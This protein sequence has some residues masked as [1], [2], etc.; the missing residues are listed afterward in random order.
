M[1]GIPFSIYNAIFPTGGI[2]VKDMAGTIYGNIGTT[3]DY[4]TIRAYGTVGLSHT[5]KVVDGATAIANK[6][7]N[8]NALSTTGAKI[9]S[10]YSDNGITEKAYVDKNGKVGV[11]GGIDFVSAGA[12]AGLFLSGEPYV[13]FS[14]RSNISIG[15]HSLLYGKE[16][17]GYRSVI[18]GSDAFLSGMVA[19]TE[20]I[21]IGSAA[22]SY[23]GYGFCCT[24]SIYLG[25]SAGSYTHGQN[26]IYLGCFMGGWQTRDNV[27]HIGY[28][29]N[30]NAL[31]LIYGEFDTKKLTIY[32]D[33]YVANPDTL[34][35]ECLSET[36]FAT[37]AKWNVT[38]ACDDTLGYVFFT[39]VGT[40]TQTQANLATP[41]KG[42]KIYKLT[43]VVAS[44]SGTITLTTGVA[45]E[46]IAIAG[47]AL[48][49]VNQ[50]FRTKASPVDFVISASAATN[51]R[52]NSVS[53]KEVQGGDLSIGRNITGYGNLDIRGAAVFNDDSADVDFRVESNGDANALVVDGGNDNVG[54]GVAADGINGKAHIK[55]GNTSGA[56]PVLTLEQA[57]ISEEFERIIGES[58]AD[59]TCSLADAADLSV[60]G[61]IVGWKKIYVEDKA[62]A[63]SIADGYYWVPFYAT[64]TAP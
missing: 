44:G 28:G 1:R 53:L 58:A 21:A 31:A 10:F 17:L 19:S 12:S 40:L 54:I 56:K 14:S 41:L 9:A 55:Q 20:V 64:P 42:S 11:L 8:S 7:G 52:L 34:G 6:F 50:Y 22:G 51:L 38:G 43:Y 39:G 62:A 16:G 18:I 13:N 60:P 3:L 25:V 32:G 30:V 49:S 5:G 57:D 59:N 15:Y 24:N 45:D 26:G 37:H 33:Q 46:T 47:G 35:P 63:G 29:T 61:A 4:D 2:N 27:L 23:S 48:G 36:D